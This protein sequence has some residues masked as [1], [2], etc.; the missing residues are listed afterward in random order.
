MITLDADNRYVYIRGAD[1]ATI[2]ALERA[3]SY[4]VQG[5]MHSMAF[6]L[7]RW[8]GREHLMQFRTTE[9]SGY[10]VPFGLL[11]DVVGVLNEMDKRH[12]LVFERRRRPERHVEYE[13][14]S[15]IE[16][17][18]YQHE[19][20]QAI[21]DASRWDVCRG[22]LK[23]PIR[24]GKTKTAARVIHDMKVRT[25]F[26]VTSQMLLHQTKAALEDA[27]KMDVGAIGDSGWTEGDV[28]VAMI[29]TLGRARGRK[30]DRKKGTPAIP[31]D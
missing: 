20:I 4:L 5:F 24:S 27:L 19:A 6:K 10:R 30:A 14:N 1:W 16:L 15:S 17:R 26:I 12:K 18:P 23:M 29:Q 3:T 21:T 9:P 13:W 25:L 31:M 8:D 28:T 2:R 11:G 7:K 22:I